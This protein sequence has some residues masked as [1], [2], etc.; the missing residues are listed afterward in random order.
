MV[1]DKVMKRLERVICCNGGGKKVKRQKKVYVWRKKTLDWKKK[2]MA[3]HCTLH[4]PSRMNN[5]S[6]ILFFFF[7]YQFLNALH[8]Q[9]FVGA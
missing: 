1:L 7:Y 6:W 9:K 5:L 4:F 2:N 8:G 3:A